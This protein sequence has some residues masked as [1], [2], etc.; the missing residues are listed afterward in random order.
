MQETPTFWKHILLL[1]RHSNI[2]LLKWRST[3]F[4]LLLGRSHTQMYLHM[5][6][7]TNIFLG[8]IF[9]NPTQ[10]TWNHCG[11]LSHFTH[12]NCLCC[13]CLLYVVTGWHC[14][15]HDKYLGW[16]IQLLVHITTGRTF[17]CV[18][19]AMVWL[20]SG[21]VITS[22]LA[23]QGHFRSAVSYGHFLLLCHSC[24]RLMVFWWL[25][26]ATQSLVI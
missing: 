9:F 12:S 23:G 22:V 24:T 19:L 6:I 13:Q 2:S 10:I 25:L 16:F 8:S 26:Y 20:A 11:H 3:L 5:S 17:S 4:S 21:A 7:W 15:M 18:D 14:C 1:I